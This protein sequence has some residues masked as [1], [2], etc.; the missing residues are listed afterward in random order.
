MKLEL[1]NVCK[2]YDKEVLKSIDC[3]FEKGVYGLLGAN[4]AGKSTLIRLICGLEDVTKGEIKYDGVNTRNLGEKYREKL[5]YLPQNMGFYPE[6]TAYEFLKYLACMKGI[7]ESKIET[8]INDV[9]YLVGL[10]NIGKKRIKNFSGGMKQRLGIA[11]AVLGYPQL[12]VLDEPTVGLDLDERMRFKQFIAEYSI[13]HTV[14]LATH[15]VSDI[16]DIAKEIVVIKEGRVLLKAEPENLLNDMSGKVWLVECSKNEAL[17]MK[18]E[19]KV[20]NMKTDGETIIIRIISDSK[21]DCSAKEVNA[22]LQDLYLYCFDENVIIEK[23]K[24]R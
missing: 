17:R 22:N 7:S 8:D 16:E 14:I 4:G 18:R 11:Q 23:R 12:L 1:I 6:F 19:Y 2:K 15:I 5:G 24:K 20:S 10:H 13:D 21:P 3:V 9:L